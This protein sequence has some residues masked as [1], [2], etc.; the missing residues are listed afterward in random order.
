MGYF[1]VSSKP[2]LS[3]YQG[4]IYTSIANIEIV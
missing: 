2:S 1:L 4:D 3:V